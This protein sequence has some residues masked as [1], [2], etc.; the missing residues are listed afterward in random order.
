MRNSSKA[1][2]LTSNGFFICYHV[3]NVYIR[4]VIG[5]NLKLT[6]EQHKFLEEN[7]QEFGSSQRFISMAID[8][9][10]AAYK[11]EKYEKMLNTLKLNQ[12]DTD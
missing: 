2:T 5:K 1:I 10:I 12:Y 6:P 7:K 3:H 11:K 9:K 8:E 4:F